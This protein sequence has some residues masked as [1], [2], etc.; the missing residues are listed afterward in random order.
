VSFA[1]VLCDSEPPSNELHANTIVVSYAPVHRL[2]RKDGKD[3]ADKIVNPL[4]ILLRAEHAGG[5][6]AQ[7]PLP[8]A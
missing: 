4:C 2:T 1:D 3:G 5:N 8:R 6:V 7:R